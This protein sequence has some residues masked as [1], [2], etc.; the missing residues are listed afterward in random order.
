MSRPKILD[1]VE[2]AA[3]RKYMQM[4]KAGSSQKFA[5]Y[6]ANGLEFSLLNTVFQ[7]VINSGLPSKIVNHVFEKLDKAF[8]LT[9]LYYK[10]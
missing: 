8:K 5:A 1:L 10:Q 6:Q 3:N 2:K 4:I 7:K 9:Q